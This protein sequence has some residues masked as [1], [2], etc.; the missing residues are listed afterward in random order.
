MSRSRVLLVVAVLACAA[1]ARAEGPAPAGRT[2]ARADLPALAEGLGFDARTGADGAVSF[3]VD[4]DGWR[5]EVN[6]DL[7]ADGT[8]LQVFAPLR[9][10]STL[11]G[12]PDRVLAGLLEATAAHA[13]SRFYLFRP[14]EGGPVVGIVRSVDNRALRAKHVREQIDALVAHARVTEDL[15]NPDRWATSAPDRPGMPR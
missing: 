13:P 14:S 7:A 8:K 10:W 5:M 15:W 11:D 3:V 1:V 4:R 2:I 6:L 12:A 9:R